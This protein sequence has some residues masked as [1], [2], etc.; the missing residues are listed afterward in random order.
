MIAKKNLLVN[1]MKYFLYM[2]MTMQKLTHAILLTSIWTNRQ[3]TLGFE[4][5]NRNIT[6]ESKF[7]RNWNIFVV[8][9]ITF[10]DMFV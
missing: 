7:F 5:S 10:L 2:H 4:S 6:F 3:L 9:N 8:L 1:L